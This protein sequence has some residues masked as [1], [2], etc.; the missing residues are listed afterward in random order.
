MGVSQLDA[1]SVLVNTQCSSKE[2]LTPGHRRSRRRP[3]RAS[4]CGNSPRATVW[5]ASQGTS[6]HLCLG[7]HFQEEFH[8]G[9]LHRG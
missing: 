5:V 2:W 9:V 8:V 6:E 3:R 7:L 4:M 1:L